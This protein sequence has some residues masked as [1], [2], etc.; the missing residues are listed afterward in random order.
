MFNLIVL[1]P[2]DAPKWGGNI[3][4]S[5]VSISLKLYAIACDYCTRLRIEPWPLTFCCVL[6]KT[7]QNLLSECLSP[8]RGING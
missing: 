4:Y 3:T 1:H 6:G 5:C 7:Q 2:E 8:P